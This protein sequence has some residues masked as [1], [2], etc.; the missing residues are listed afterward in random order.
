MLWCAAQTSSEGALERPAHAKVNT[1]CPTA[2]EETRQCQWHPNDPNA[3]VS[4]W[5]SRHFTA[6]PPQFHT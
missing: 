3:N 4:P 6:K 5:H 1:S 2:C